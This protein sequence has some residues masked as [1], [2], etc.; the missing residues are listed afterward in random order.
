MNDKELVRL[1]THLE[2]P[3][4][5]PVFKPA[6]ALPANE[7]GPPAENCQLDPREDLCDDNSQ[8]ADD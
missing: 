8:Q 1:L 2:L 4:G 5:F 7:C 6:M 3:T